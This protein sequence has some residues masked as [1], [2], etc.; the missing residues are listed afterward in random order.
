M[1]ESKM[2]AV[3]K[4]QPNPEQPRK[5]FVE[6]ELLELAESI[7]EHGLIQPIIVTPNG[8]PD[9]FILVDSERRWRATQLA[10]LKTIDAVVK[11][12]MEA[13]QMLEQALV[14]NLHRSDLNPIEEARAYQ[15][16]IERFHLTG[17]K[18]ARRVGKSTARVYHLLKLLKLE[19]E[20][21]D[22]IAVY[23]LPKDERVADAFLTVPAGET[24]IKLATRLAQN[25][26]KIK[27]VE[28]ACSKVAQALVSQKA[29]SAQPMVSRAKERAS[30]EPA[31]ADTVTVDQ[32]R[33]AASAMCAGCEIKSE[34]L[35]GQVA[36]PGWLLVVNAAKA[37]C[38]NC[39][40][41]NVAGA[42][43]ACPGVE[44]LRNIIEASKVKRELHKYVTRNR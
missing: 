27:T 39:G 7:K 33:A 34:V 30:R 18:V 12:K 31:D 10:G 19:P 20:I 5:V 8:G 35:K 15:Q 41:S 44:L 32:L 26:A 29:H 1:S 40:M 6:A 14:A 43:D 9:S 11:S 38:Q 37:T 13:Q 24:R 42:C 4:I 36:E 16:L 3:K 23:A 22:L 28:L 2:I 25:K 21:Q 17:E